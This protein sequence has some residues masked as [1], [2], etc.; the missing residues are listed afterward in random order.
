MK[1]HELTEENSQ[2]NWGYDTDQVVAQFKEFADD[3]RKAAKGSMDD[4]EPED[5][6][7]MR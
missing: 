1:L 4:L 7:S 5:A 6:D 3:Y 2:D